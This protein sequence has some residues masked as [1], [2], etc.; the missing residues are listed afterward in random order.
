MKF[1]PNPQDPENRER[2]RSVSGIRWSWCP[3]QIEYSWFTRTLQNQ[4]IVILQGHYMFSKDITNV[5]QKSYRDVTGMLQRYH[6]LYTD[7]PDTLQGYYSV[8][9]D[10]CF[11]RILQICYKDITGMLQTCYTDITGFTRILQTR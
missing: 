2:N 1:P 9:T 5:L 6:K 8:V 10:M 7:V 4:F 11:T 3:D